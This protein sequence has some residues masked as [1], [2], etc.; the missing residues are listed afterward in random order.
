MFK[1]LMQLIKWLFQGKP[2]DVKELTIV[3]MKHFPFSGYS[4]MSWCGRL[5]TRKIEKIGE[6]TINHETTHLKQAQQYS[7]W[8]MYYL[9]YL[10]EWIKGNPLIHPASS[11]YYTIPFEVEAYA[12]ELR[13]GYNDN[14]DPTLLKKK[15]T[16][17]KRKKLYKEKGYSYGW[18]EYIRSL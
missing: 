7:C 12:N 15:Y 13:N 18:K 14:Y 2:Q 11:A 6:R 5:V 9:V 8:L 16:F 17:K 4:A 3:K 10:F 1:E